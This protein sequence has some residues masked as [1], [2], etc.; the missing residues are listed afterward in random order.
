MFGVV[1]CALYDVCCSLCVACC[2]LCVLIGVVCNVSCEVC[3]SVVCAVDC[4]LMAVAHF[5]FV[6][7]CVVSFVC[8]MSLFVVCC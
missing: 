2:V 5:L 7:D 3:S 1:R 6:V 8:D 4:C